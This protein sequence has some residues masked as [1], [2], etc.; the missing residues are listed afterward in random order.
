LADYL[1]GNAAIED[2]FVNPGIEKLT[3]LPGGKPLSNSSEL[4]GSK[5]MEELVIDLKN[6]YRNDRIVIFDSPAMLACTDPLVFSHLIDGVI[7]VVQA[8]RTSPDDIRRVVDLLQDRPI[9]GTVLNKSKEPR[10]TYV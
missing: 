10:E 1:L 6:R 8:E 5:R 3:I 4:L 7:I 2:V 9:L